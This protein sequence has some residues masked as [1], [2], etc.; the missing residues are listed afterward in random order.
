MGILQRYPA[1]RSLWIGQLFS[2]LGNAVFLIMGLWEIQLRSPV[3]LSVAGIAMVLPT[4]LAAGGGVI[5]DR[6]DAGRL[7][8]W[9]DILR[10]VAVAAGLAALLIP[11]SLVPDVIALLAVNSLGI[12]LFGPA[13]AIMVP[14]LVG[15]DDL[16]AAN[17]VY[18]LTNQ[19]STAVGSAIGG[20]A[21][22]AVGAVWVFGFD[23]GSFWISALAISLMLR[24]VLRTSKRQPAP[25]GSQG[26]QSSFGASMREGFAVVRKL[27]AVIDLLPV[28][29]LLNFAF[30][31]AFTMLP[32]WIH[33]VL[34]AS[35]FWY[36]LIN[37]GWAA[38]AIVGSLSTGYFRRMSTRG[39]STLMFGLMGLFFG[40]FALSGTPLLS[41][42]LL[43]LAGIANSVGNAV[44]FTLFQR[45]IPEEV[46]GRAFGLIFTIF[47]LANPLGSLAAGLLL[48][49]LP[50][51]WSW[52]LGVLSSLALTI[53]M[54]RLV[55]ADLGTAEEPAASVD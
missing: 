1:F 7:M 23:M 14:R 28:I 29:L 45:I 22:A 42:G 54:W 51:Y 8:L 25:S 26:P 37:A 48:H 5:V 35:A 11:G 24:A 50:L 33:H 13:E 47:G 40:A 39:V 49:L 36:G 19:I 52:A 10:G 53:G 17:G 4:L 21:I 6:Y 18:N 41:G 9:T 3:L 2:Q 20:A 27:P 16:A 31:A 15:A 32:Y 43:L 12:A 34:H 46:R 38:G 44:M 55:P 30:M